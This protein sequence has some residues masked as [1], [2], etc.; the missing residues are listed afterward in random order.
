MRPTLDIG[1]LDQFE[2]N[3]SKQYAYFVGN[4]HNIRNFV[5]A[6][7][8]LKKKQ[9]HWAADPKFF[10]SNPFFADWLRSLP[11]ELQINYPADNSPPW[12][13]SHFVANMHSHFH[14]GI[15]LLHRPQ[16]V[17]SK[18]FA[19]GG[20]WRIHLSLCYSSAKKLCRLQEAVLGY[21]GLSGLLFMQRGINFTIYCILVCT[22]LHLV[23]TS[24]FC[25][26]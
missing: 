22:M 7:H 16:L 21:Y 24:D 15:I 5:G 9:T 13:P 8:K 4:A 10:E 18:S 14:L 19:A 12:I 26:T 20:D 11:P 6:F 2:I 17:A 1:G 23:S 3:Q 25:F